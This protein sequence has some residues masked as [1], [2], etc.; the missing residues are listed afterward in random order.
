[1]SLASYAM[2]LVIAL[3][4][5][6][7]GLLDVTASGL[8]VAAAGILV[9]QS[10]FY[11]LIASGLNLRFRDPSLTLPQILVGLAWALFLIAVSREIRGVMLIVYMITLLF[12]IFALDKRQFLIAGATAYAGYALL[13]VIEQSRGLDYFS[14][15]Y[16]VVSLIVLGGVLLWTTLFGSYVSNLRYK[17][18]AR[19]EELEQ[20]LVRMRELA[21][22]DDLTGLFNRRVI[23]ELLRQMKARADRTGETFSVC[24]IDLD[25]FKAVN[26]EYGHLTGDR[27]LAAFSRDMSRE[28]REMDFLAPGNPSLGRYGGEEFI[29]LLPGTDEAG[30]RRC[31]E[32]LR[33][34]QAARAGGRNGPGCTL[35][36]GVAEYRA[37]EDIE[38]VLRRADRALYA[39]KQT[40]R[41]RVC[42]AE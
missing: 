28:L 18:Q 21:D 11:A 35:S 13:V 17:L 36:A 6:R 9:T 39:A 29:L 19:N 30:A 15:G 14:D 10:A 42:T 41:N 26:D 34:R 33:G 4:C 37:G 12:G 5:W 22:H 2:W 31:A 1:M 7:V 8:A 23:M 32:R 24:I 40:G 25:N 38:S 27:I 3:I 20:V 16:Y